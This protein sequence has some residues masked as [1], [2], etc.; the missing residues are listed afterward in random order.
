MSWVALIN[1]LRSRIKVFEPFKNISKQ[2]STINAILIS[3]GF[4]K[5]P[6]KTVMKGTRGESIEES[7][8]EYKNYLRRGGEKLIDSIV[9]FKVVNRYFT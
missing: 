5:R 3:Y 9:F 7:R 6:S 8:K 4:F 2:P 1:K